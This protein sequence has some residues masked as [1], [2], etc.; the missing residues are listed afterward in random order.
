MQYVPLAISSLPSF[1]LPTKI[2]INS[3]HLLVNVPSAPPVELLEGLR[4]QQALLRLLLL[5]EQQAG[6][7]DER[8]SAIWL[9]ICNNIYIILANVLPPSP[10]SFW[11]LPPPPFPPFSPPFRPWLDAPPPSGAGT[12]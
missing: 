8:L 3:A 11:S 2:A 12:K 7:G 6:P 4:A 9:V 5:E 10:L 1:P